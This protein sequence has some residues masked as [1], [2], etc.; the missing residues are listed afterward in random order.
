MKKTPPLV[1]GPETLSEQNSHPEDSVS[2]SAS[3]LPEFERLDDQVRAEVRALWWR[4]RRRGV[5]LPAE[6]GVIV[7]DGGRR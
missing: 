3:Q 6:R 7:V 4:M 5:D 1:A 2:S